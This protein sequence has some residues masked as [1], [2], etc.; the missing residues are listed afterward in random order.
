[1]D[2]ASGALADRAQEIWK[3][4]SGGVRSV[5]GRA[6]DWWQAAQPATRRTVVIA[7][8][9][10]V[11]MIMVLVARSIL[12]EPPPPPPSPEAQKAYA[13]IQRRISEGMRARND[14]AGISAGRAMPGQ[15]GVPPARSTRP[16]LGV[17]PRGQ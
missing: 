3:G 8:S 6:A 14:A 11:L 13:D 5:S 10:V 4:D 16:P 7:G 9:G 17:P 2:E 1:M 12:A 15:K